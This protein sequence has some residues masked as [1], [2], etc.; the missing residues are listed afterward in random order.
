MLP[1]RMMEPRPTPK[2]GREGVS[3]DMGIYSFWIAARL[4]RLR[5]APP[6]IRTWY[7]LTLAM[8]G[9]TT[10]GRCPAPAMFLGHSEA[11]KPI[12]VSI[13]LWWG[14]TFSTGAAAATMQC[15]VLMTRLDVM[16]QEPPYM[17]WSCSRCSSVLESESEWP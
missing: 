15:S 5:A 2:N 3:L 4:M 9:E 16:S 12:D 10:N 6:S 13:H 8:V 14:A 7:S 11:S 17:T 1:H